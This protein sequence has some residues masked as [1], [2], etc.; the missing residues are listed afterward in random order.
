MDHIEDEREQNMRKERATLAQQSRR[1]SLRRRSWH[2]MRDWANLQIETWSTRDGHET[3]SSTV[4][5]LNIVA[6]LCPSGFLSI[7]YGMDGIGYVPAFAIM[8][9]SCACSCYTMWIV[10]RACEI[11]GEFDYASQWASAIGP[12]AAWV[13]N[14]VICVVALGA[15]LCYACYF[16]DL[17]QE[18]TPAFGYAVPRY[19][20]VIGASLFPT[21]P[22]CY[23]K[24]LSALGCSSGFAFVALL[25]TAVVMSIRAYDGTYAKGGDFYKELPGGLRPDLPWAPD[26]APMWQFG[27]QSLV[28]INILA[29]AFHCHC[30][31][32]KYYRELHKSTP[33]HFGRC[34]FVAMVIC[35]FIYAVMGYMGY[36]T[37]GLAAEGTILKNYSVND[38]PINIAKCGVVLSLIASY[39]I[40]FAALRESSLSLLKGVGESWVGNLDLIW[41]QDVLSTVLVVLITSLAVLCQDSGLVDGLV[42]AICGNVVIYI[43]PCLIYAA[44]VKAFFDKARNVPSIASSVGLV[45]FG[46]A[47]I[48]AGCFC[49]VYYELPKAST[50]FKDV[51]IYSDADEA[52]KSRQ[53]HRYKGR[54]NFWF[55]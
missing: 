3:M 47:L 26:H 40:M 7:A 8:V 4:F 24:N 20:C 10:G 51:A 48:I 9:V 2:L 29:M 46:V 52:V 35:A 17:L 25:Y 16:G 18:V 14:L 34:T 23:L 33:A 36:K 50:Q 54:H 44:S 45:V 22:L 41:R 21:L 42:G 6:D 13:P 19:A 38:W 27:G 11:T 43:I 1:T 12:R 55:R 15:L 53:E 49:I 5:V 39:G 31:A 30:N 28:Y 37:F 32:C